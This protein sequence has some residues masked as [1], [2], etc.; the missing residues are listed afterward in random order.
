MNMRRLGKNGPN[1]SIMGLGT[2]ALAGDWEYG[3][4]AQDYGDS[5]ETIETAI[6]CGI[7]WIDTAAVYGNGFA[8]E[9]VSAFSK[10]HDLFI[11][12][13]GG[14]VSDENGK[15]YKNLDPNSILLE[16]EASLRRLKIDIIDLYQ[17]HWPDPKRSPLPAWE[18]LVKLKETGK[19]QYIGLSNFWLRDLRDICNMHVPQSLQAPLNLIDSSYLPEVLLYCQNNNI[20]F[21]GYSPLQSGLLTDSFSSEQKLANLPLND[22]RRKNKYFRPPLLP[23]IKNYVNKLSEIAE[24]EGLSVGQLST[25]WVLHQSGVTATIMGARN[26]HQ[27]RE[28]CQ[29]ADVILSSDALAKIQKLKDQAF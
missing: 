8:E 16:V 10:K 15:I 9:L 12:T 23:K 25:A 24:Q 28:N 26:A 6:E 21:L 29:A 7:N 18:K 2:W 19:I 22:W 11:A 14:L 4:G 3:W 20:G 13:K 5:I 1:F 17:L 27:V